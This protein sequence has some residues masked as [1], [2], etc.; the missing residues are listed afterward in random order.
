MDNTE[1]IDMFEHIE[2]L[3]Q[4]VQAIIEEHTRTWEEK[5]GTITH[6]FTHFTLNAD[7]HP[8][9]KRFHRPGEEKRGVAILRPEYYDDWLSSTN[10]EFA[11]V[12]IE[13]RTETE[14]QAF[15]APK[16][17]LDDDEVKD[18]EPPSPEPQSA[19]QA[20]LF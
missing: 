11:R 12:L 10:P 4:E 14:L 3:P 2:D 13:L 7:D 6:S 20:S 19:P 16:V 15:A 17:A 5:D 8:L 9:L 18:A 1:E